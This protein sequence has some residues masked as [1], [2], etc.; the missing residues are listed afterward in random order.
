MFKILML[1]V[2][3]TITGCTVGVYN[4]QDLPKNQREYGKTANIVQWEGYIAFRTTVRDEVIE[5]QVSTC[6]DYYVISI[7]DDWVIYRILKY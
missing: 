2:L 3:L 1:S 7:S 5:Q 4:V 6:Q